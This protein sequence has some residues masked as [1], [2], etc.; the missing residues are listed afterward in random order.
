MMLCAKRVSVRLAT[1]DGKGVTLVDNFSAEIAP[2]EL[3]MVVGPNGAGKTTLLRCLDGELAPTE[4][5]VELAHRRLCDWPRLEL[6]RKRAVLPQQSS[7]DFPF[8][9]TDVV[10]MGRM[11]HRTSDVENRA[12]A[13]KTLAWCDCAQL[14]ARAYTSLSGG[15]QQRVQIARVLAQICG[16]R[17]D[18]QPVAQGTGQAF[19]AVDARYLLLDEPLSGLDLSHQYEILRRLKQLCARDNIGIVCTLHNLNLVAQFADRALL[20]ER[21]RL[22]AD[23]APLSVFTEQTLRQ[24]FNLEVVVR[25]HPDDDL[26]PLLVPRLA[27]ES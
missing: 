11:P 25:R 5:R 26:I 13:A 8:S 19:N 10:L 7:L 20:M 16:P 12:I 27:N 22:V 1:G 17:H 2:G 14:G 15:E 24:V 4:G 9:V 3:V 21:G 6:A 23:G 18:D